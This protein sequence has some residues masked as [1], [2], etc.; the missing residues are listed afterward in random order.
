M[1]GSCRHIGRAAAVQ[2]SLSVGFSMLTLSAR[3]A[4]SDRRVLTVFPFIRIIVNGN[5]AAHIAGPCLEPNLL[6]LTLGSG[7]CAGFWLCLACEGRRL[8]THGAAARFDGIEAVG[9]RQ[10][11]RFRFASRVLCFVLS[12][13]PSTGLFPGV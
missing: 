13:G 7:M 5:A 9:G 11:G 3:T 12:R 6:A 4:A 10:K 1:R 8:W 2:G